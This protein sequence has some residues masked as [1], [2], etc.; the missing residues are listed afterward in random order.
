MFKHFH[1]YRLL[2]YQ[3]DQSSLPRLDK[4][5]LLLYH[6]FSSFVNFGPNL[7]KPT[8]DMGGMA[9]QHRRISIDYF[10]GVVDN[11]DLAYEHGGILGW[12]SLTLRGYIA[13]F[14]TLIFYL[15][16]D[17]VSGKSFIHFLVMHFDRADCSGQ[18]SRTNSAGTAWL[19]NARFHSSN[20]Y[21][22]NSLDLVYVVDR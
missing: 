21:G 3:L 12:V 2:R 22:S 11:Y 18:V 5:R 9:V 8:S 20:C 13:A 10:A 1:H 7:V 17:I 4:L 14:H 16:P 6:L 19:Q 15:E